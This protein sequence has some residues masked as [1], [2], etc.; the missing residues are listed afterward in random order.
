[1]T[2]IEYK[3]LTTF[4]NVKLLEYKPDIEKVGKSAVSTPKLGAKNEL[5]K[6]KSNNQFLRIAKLFEGINKREGA[7]EAMPLDLDSVFQ[8]LNL[9]MSFQPSR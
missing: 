2:Y 8:C 9:W 4:N 3:N 1:M 6:P 7:K 5:E